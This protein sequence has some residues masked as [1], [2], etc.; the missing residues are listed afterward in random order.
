MAKRLK[1]FF[2]G[3]PTTDV[4]ISLAELLFFSDF[5][6]F[7]QSSSIPGET[8]QDFQYWYTCTFNRIYV[9]LVNNLVIHITYSIHVNKVILVIKIAPPPIHPPT[10]PAT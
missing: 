7:K 10:H 2:P 4:L 1:S 6:L 3:R 5:G 8:A 9:G